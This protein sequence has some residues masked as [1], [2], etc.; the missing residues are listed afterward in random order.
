MS[1]WSSISRYEVSLWA[2]D[3][4]SLLPPEQHKQFNPACKTRL[5]VGRNVAAFSVYSTN[6]VFDAYTM[7]ADV[8]AQPVTVVLE[9]LNDVYDNE[10]GWDRNLSVSHLSFRLIEMP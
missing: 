10:H 4:G 6:R 2:R 9:F 1:P 5:W 7:Q 3:D 8:N